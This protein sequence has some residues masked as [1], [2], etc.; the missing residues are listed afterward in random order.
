MKK[1]YRINSPNQ[2]YKIDDIEN[3]PHG[4]VYAVLYHPTFMD[5][6]LVRLEDIGSKWFKTMED[7]IKQRIKNLEK[8]LEYE[9]SLL[10]GK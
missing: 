2:P 7:C 6:K 10:K 1:L 3:Q 8:E 5:I 4:Y 9:K